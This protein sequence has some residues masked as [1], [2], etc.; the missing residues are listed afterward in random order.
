MPDVAQQLLDRAN[1]VATGQQMRGEGMAESVAR[2]AFGDGR[3]A[4]RRR[5]SRRSSVVDGMMTPR[6]FRSIPAGRVMRSSLRGC[7]SRHGIELSDAEGKQVESAV[8]TMPLMKPAAQARDVIHAPGSEGIPRLRVGLPQTTTIRTADP[9]VT[10]LIACVRPDN[11]A[12]RRSLTCACRPPP[13]QC[14]CGGR[15]R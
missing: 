15:G 4:N 8:R 2:N 9:S 11:P 14:G 6:H 3:S 5:D 7:Q 13:V 10:G 1:I 12:A